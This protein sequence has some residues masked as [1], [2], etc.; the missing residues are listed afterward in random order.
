MLSRNRFAIMKRK[1]I[2]K[3][4]PY[5]SYGTESQ[6]QIL[7]RSVLQPPKT[8]SPILKRGFSQLFIKQVP[9]VEVEVL[10]D[11]EESG[12]ILH[13]D[14]NGYINKK[15]QVHLAPG[16]HTVHYKITKDYELHARNP[17]HAV[18]VIKKPSEDVFWNSKVLVISSDQTVGVISDIDDTI[19][20]SQ[21]PFR[22][23]AAFKLL[24]EN[25]HKRKVVKG[26]NELFKTI[27]ELWPDVFTIYLSATPWNMYDISR[28]FI[29]KLNFPFGPLILQ[30]L[31]PSE[32]KIFESSKKHKQG[33]LNKLLADF[34]K[35][36]WIL[37]GDNG[38]HDPQIYSAIAANSPD[39]ILA[40][41]IRQ[42]TPFNAVRGNDNISVQLAAPNGFVLAK[43]LKEIFEECCP[44]S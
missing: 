22:F 38:Q 36:K 6:V 24:L 35:T 40:I 15:L 4:V 11:D 43:Q 29:S 1:Y 26:M 8:K 16:L 5:I 10:F 25:P 3:L 44:Q 28:H 19:M 41:L 27:Y 21:V 2:L 9:G 13:T 34:P 17:K 32:N 12:Q 39:R 37:I 18:A 20:T 23:I 14:N 31:G 42:L 7:L 33:Y 30:D